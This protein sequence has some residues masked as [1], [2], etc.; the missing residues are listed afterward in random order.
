MFKQTSHDGHHFHGR[1]S[2][3]TWHCPA[4][5]CPFPVDCNCCG[6]SASHRPQSV[7]VVVAVVPV[8]SPHRLRP[9]QRAPVAVAAAER[10]HHQRYDSWHSSAAHGH[11]ALHHFRYS[12]G[13][14][15]TIRCHTIADSSVVDTVTSADCNHRHH[16]DCYRSS[17]ARD[18]VNRS[19]D[20]VDTV[21]DSDR[22]SGSRYCHGF[23]CAS[24]VE[25]VRPGPAA[26]LADIVDAVDRGHGSSDDRRCDSDRRCVRRTV[27]RLA[28][29]RN[30][31]HRRPRHC[32]RRC[33]HCWRHL[34]YCYLI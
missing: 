10:D 7:A 12:C 32:Y 22:S 29:N 8:G 28:T 18:S 34:C 6:P 11:R 5:P 31:G 25:A 27:D 14:D 26:Q 13:Y 21:A 30:L 24:A 1:N 2:S 19:L 16:H 23:D 15:R 20:A 4:N 33:C 3:H 9:A 17:H